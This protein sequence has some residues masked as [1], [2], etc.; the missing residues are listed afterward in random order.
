MNLKICLILLSFHLIT[1]NE[2]Q[3]VYT[4]EEAKKICKELEND[5]LEVRKSI[6]N[7]FSEK[8]ELNIIEIKKEF[9]EFIKKYGKF[10]KIYDKIDE[11]RQLSVEIH[12]NIYNL[13][14]Y[15]NLVNLSR[16]NNLNHE[17]MELY[18]NKYLID[19]LQSCTAIK[20]KDFDEFKLAQLEYEYFTQ[21]YEFK[22]DKN[23]ILLSELTKCLENLVQNAR[24]Y[25][26][27]RDFLKD[28]R[29][30]YN[31]WI[32]QIKKFVKN[33]QNK[34]DLNMN[35]IEQENLEFCNKIIER[36]TEKN[37]ETLK[38][39]F[40]IIKEFS[41][42]K[43]YINKFKKMS[44]NFMQFYKKINKF[45]YNR[46]FLNRFFQFS[47]E[48]NDEHKNKFISD[49]IKFEIPPYTN[50]TIDNFDTKKLIAEM[51]YLCDIRFEFFELIKLQ[52]YVPANSQG[53]Q[54]TLGPPSPPDPTG[55]PS[56]PDPTGPEIKEKRPTISNFFYENLIECAFFIIFIF[57]HIFR[58]IYDSV[59]QN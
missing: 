41:I 52:F 37:Y 35:I 56:P 53:S 50:L 48:I 15:F 28:V 16:F 38:Q 23:H 9:E 7:Y 14:L 51:K 12:S 36:I 33:E 19:Q 45:E 20:N 1:N 40:D 24:N 10:F 17:M 47:F 39:K 25:V 21:S 22:N 43:E 54:G 27:F 58:T 5:L 3:K 55:P 8:I 4:E 49:F 30:K 29:P 26:I 57:L 2:D 31:S 18:E 44:K 13:V 6:L 32:L 34:L 59:Y 42:K 11:L 46:I